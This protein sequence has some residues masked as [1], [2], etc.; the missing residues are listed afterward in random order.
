[1]KLPALVLS[2]ASILAAGVTYTYDSA[3]R[4]ATVT[5]SNGSNISYTYDKAGNV[6]SRSV[7]TAAGPSITSVSVANGGADIAQNTWIAIKGFNLVPPDT[8]SS[9]VIWSN[10]PE[11]AAGKLPAQLNGISVKVNGNPAFVYFYCSAVTS[12]VCASDQVNVLTPLDS[13]LGPAQIVVTN[14]ATS[15][16]AFTSNLK[17][18]APAFLLFNTAG[19]AAATHADGSLLG[20]PTLFPGLSTSAA[21]NEV[22]IV[23]GV[24]FGLP[25]TS[26]VNG[27]AT[28]SGTLPSNPVCQ[29]GS[30]N[31]SI[32]FAGLI[33]PGLYQFNMTVPAAAKSGPN[34]L[35]CTYGG[36]T[37]AAGALISV[38]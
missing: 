18:V 3:G 34:P 16:P 4:L 29:L 31:V 23:Y 22:I 19:N 28:Q 32:S 25:S 17:T 15:S 20:P 10:A 35:T 27:S 9:G 21:P 36:A 5:Y 11:F 8:P 30:N 24:G 1:M 6:V 33:S 7:Q 37:T 38:Q 2:I 14:G 26:L 13:T 12:P